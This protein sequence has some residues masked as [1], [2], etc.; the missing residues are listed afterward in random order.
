MVRQLFAIR[1]HAVCLPLPIHLNFS[2]QR[3]AMQTLIAAQIAKLPDPLL[4]SVA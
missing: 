4:Q 2:A 3:K 1:H